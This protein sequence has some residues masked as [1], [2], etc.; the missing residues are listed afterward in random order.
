MSKVHEGKVVGIK[1]IEC[2]KRMTKW[3]A[4]KG[5]WFY[6]RHCKKRQEFE[7]FLFSGLL[8]SILGT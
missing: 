5:A 2:Y 6:L 3:N 1:A 4:K 8:S 7:F